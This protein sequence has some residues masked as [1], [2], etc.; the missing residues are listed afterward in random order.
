[1]A[2]TPISTCTQASL[3]RSS[4]SHNFL[5]FYLLWS[6]KTT[7]LTDRQSS[8]TLRP[9]FLIMISQ[10]SNDFQ[11]SLLEKLWLSFDT[12]A[13][14]Q[15]GNL[16]HRYLFW[17]NSDSNFPPI[18]AIWKKAVNVLLEL[19]TNNP[20]FLKPRPR[21]VEKRGKFFVVLSIL[22]TL[23]RDDFSHFHLSFGVWSLEVGKITYFRAYHDP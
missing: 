18:S 5:N 21:K 17:R 6:T 20:K 12:P 8:S 14:R 4:F 2:G 16:L 3:R 1:M 13:G 9:M 10:T 15:P 19:L 23:F 22:S 7:R 11:R